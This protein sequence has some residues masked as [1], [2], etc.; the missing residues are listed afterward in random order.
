[1]KWLW[2]SLIIAASAVP[3]SAWS[4]DVKIASWNV[5]ASPYEKVLT[6]TSDYK[7]MADTLSPDVIVMVEL[8]GR[9]DMKAIAE[10]IGWPTYYAAVSDWQVQGSEIHASL[11]VGVLSKIP[12]VSVIEYDPKPEGRIN[13]VFT[14]SQ[15]NG[16]VT[17]PVKEMPLKGIEKMGL[18]ASDRGTMRVDLANGL[19]LFPVHLKSNSNDACFAASDT[20]SNLKKLGLPAMPALQEILDQGSASKAKADKDNAFKRER[21]IAA[22][23]SVADPAI[24]EGRTVV[25]AGDW[26]TSFEPGKFGQSFD[27]CQLQAFSCAKAPFEASACS[28]DGFDD[29][30][31]ILTVPLS[32]TEKWEM[33]SKGLG[34]TFEDKAFADKAIDHIAVPIAKASEFRGPEVAAGTFGS[35]HF[36]I[37]TVW[38]AAP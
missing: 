38:T 31:A 14:A 3:G 16:D 19:T 30:F 4:A 26:N 15:P 36:P 24:N 21:V 23:K 20:I 11:E 22:T 35:D 7:S 13:K 5:A 32:G 6:R 8:T 17:I 18:A 1:M 9:E 2:G 10:A 28:G 37:A 12:I 29:T 34:R 33:L 25:I 27:D